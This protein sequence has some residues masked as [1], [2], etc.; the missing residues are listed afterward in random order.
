M[1]DLNQYDNNLRFVLFKNDRKEKDSHPD[2]T[3]KGEYNNV[4]CYAKGWKKVSKSG[5]P[6]ISGVLEPKDNKQYRNYC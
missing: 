1:S 4:E 6:Y 5:T 3:G 2:F